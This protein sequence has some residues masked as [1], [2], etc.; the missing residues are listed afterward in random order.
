MR[1][2]SHVEGKP[3]FQD[4]G[5]GVRLL[6]SAG[7]TLGKKSSA[8]QALGPSKRVRKPCVYSRRVAPTLA[9]LI[10]T[11]FPAKDFQ[12]LDGLRKKL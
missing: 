4:D 2:D 11:P 3:R 12:T 5:T 8:E 10:R 7:D 1:R 6:F 9:L